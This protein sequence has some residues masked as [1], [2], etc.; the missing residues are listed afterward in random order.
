MIN[1]D[2][3]DYSNTPASLKRPQF[4]YRLEDIK[5]NP[6]VSIVT[7]FYNAGFIFHETVQSV[8]RQSCQ[9]W[10]WIIIDDGSTDPKSVKILHSYRDEDPR[11]HVYTQI[12]NTGNCTA[13]NIGV[14]YATTPYVVLLDTDDLLEP[15]AL[16]KWWWYLES[17]PEYGFV[18]GYSVGFGA[19]QYVWKKGFHHGRAFLEENLATMASMVRK[20]VY[21][22]VNGFD[23]SRGKKGLNDW[24]FWLRCANS[25]YWGGVIPE[26]LDWYRRRVDHTDRWPDWSKEGKK[27]FLSE[28]RLRYPRLWEGGFPEV[29]SQINHE[30][31]AMPYELPCDNHLQKVKPRI[32]FVVSWLETTQE[33]KYLLP[34]V[35]GLVE[36]G[37]EI[38]MTAILK[39][40]HA[41]L[42][43]LSQY[44]PDVFILPHFLEPHDYP[45]FLHYLV[46]SR[47]IDA[48]LVFHCEVGKLFLPHLRSQFPK[49]S[50]GEFIPGD[51]S[52]LNGEFNFTA[53]RWESVL[54][55]IIVSSPTVKAS[56]VQQGANTKRIHAL[57]HVI[58][59]EEAIPDPH[60]RAKIRTHMGFDAEIPIILYAAHLE[61][62]GRPILFANTV[63]K[64][65]QQ[66]LQFVALAVGDGPDL[67][68]L[69]TFAIKNG[70]DVDG[71]LRVL[72]AVSST[73]LHQLL[74]AADIF[75]QP[76]LLPGTELSIY[77]AMAYELAIVGAK[78]EEEGQRINPEN[79][80]LIQPG[81][82][83][84]ET[85]QYV[86]TLTELIQRLQHSKDK[87]NEKA[88]RDKVKPHV[89]LKNIGEELHN[90]LQKGI[91][92]SPL[93]RPAETNEKAEKDYDFRAVE[94]LRLSHWSE[95]QM[96]KQRQTIKGQEE[97]NAQLEKHC[98]LWK[99]VATVRE[100]TIKKQEQDKV[101]L[102]EQRALWEGVAAE[103]EN[104]IKK[105][106]Q[107]KEHLDKERAYWE[108][109]AQGH[110][111][112]LRDLQRKL[113][114][115]LGL[116]IDKI[117]H[118]R[119]IKKR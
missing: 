100:D 29:Q 104:I 27:Q 77:R 107:D 22:A 3:P 65:H 88:N 84:I 96:E 17:H 35:K 85:E 28:M 108:T 111:S 53:R 75:F 59:T 62:K 115:R 78:W 83:E 44:S 14:R 8:L 73:R 55:H 16:E 12:K 26:Y 103:R 11:I 56:M 102:E 90:L 52:W 113:W 97:E 13:R 25:G 18:K 118:D 106:E 23:E 39:G 99:G 49:I 57:T 41:G 79:G 34:M 4:G 66:D 91:N 112:T 10:E 95:D 6:H 31:K 94:Y 7:P 92:Q 33:N 1:P 76:S 9:Q 116:Y 105:Q 40:E 98:A 69:Y 42:S 86:S 87:D 20:N 5:H 119:F 37:W 32:L 110:K 19:Y 70:L 74:T 64:L 30:P 24:E 47:Q 36:Q 93:E 2:N 38:S 51:E 21:E 67:E 50:F 80:L 81:S 46:K 48:V 61:T 58:D 60:Q 45:R 101:R 117:F 114:V 71:K 109:L 72:G 82:E 43:Q 15:T 54:D 89:S 68:W 63:L